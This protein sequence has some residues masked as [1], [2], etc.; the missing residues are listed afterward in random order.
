MSNFA[1]EQIW[2]GTTTAQ[3]S[4]AGSQR[5]DDIK[6]F[7]VLNAILAQ[8]KLLNLN[9]SSNCPGSNYVDPD[10]NLRDT[11]PTDVS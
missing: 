10:S 6:L 9:F 3:V 1:K 2:D 11:F 7:E 8:L 5:V 4:P